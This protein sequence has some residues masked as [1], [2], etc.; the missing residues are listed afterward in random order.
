MFAII[1]TPKILQCDQGTEF[2]G[3]VRLL[4]A[5]LNVRIIER[6]GEKYAIALQRW[7]QSESHR[8][9]SSKWKAGK[10]QERTSAFYSS[11]N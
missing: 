11:V 4:M 1:G 6:T 5:C 8:S 3:S 2:K 9:S 7:G 10:V